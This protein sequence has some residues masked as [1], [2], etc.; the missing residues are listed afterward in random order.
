[1]SCNADL[2][3]LSCSLQLS[4]SSTRED[5]LPHV[6]KPR[7]VRGPFDLVLEVISSKGQCCPTSSGIQHT[8]YKLGCA[9]QIKQ[10]SY[11]VQLIMSPGVEVLT[12]VILPFLLA[13]VAGKLA[14]SDSECFNAC[15]KAIAIS[16]SRSLINFNND[17]QVTLLSYQH[18]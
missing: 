9:T 12:V 3:S 4:A 11:T 15:S 6:T 5:S 16:Y 2:G 14:R 8:V 17:F 18:L 10:N 7:P 13:S 1:M